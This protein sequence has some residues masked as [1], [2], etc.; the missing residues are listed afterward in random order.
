MLEDRLHVYYNEHPKTKQRAFVLA[1]QHTADLADLREE[2]DTTNEALEVAKSNES[3][4]STGE[5][6]RSALTLQAHDDRVRRQGY[7]D[8]PW[9][10]AQPMNPDTGL[11]K[12]N[13]VTMRGPDRVIDALWI[14]VQ[15][16]N[17]PV[18]LDIS[19][20]ELI[21]GD[22]PGFPLH[23]QYAKT[24]S[25]QQ[26]IRES[27]L[28]KRKWLE[29]WRTDGGGGVAGNHVVGSEPAVLPAADSGGVDL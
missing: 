20:K 12:W 13:F 17:L 22:C 15:G 29:N 1:T 26:L 5:C 21:F 19:L 9:I 3:L 2:L 27:I 18:D 10:K 4:S 7:V 28:N 11:T 25:R 6:L 16:R 8:R 24:R 14:S 23:H